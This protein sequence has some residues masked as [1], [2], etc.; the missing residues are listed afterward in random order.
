MRL[1]GPWAESRLQEGMRSAGRRSRV[2][3]EGEE[4]TVAGRVLSR[5]GGRGERAPGWPGVLGETAP[6]AVE[7]HREAVA[8]AAGRSETACWIWYLGHGSEG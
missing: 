3:R 6:P 1:T 7:G 4:R 2:R 5:G 8:R